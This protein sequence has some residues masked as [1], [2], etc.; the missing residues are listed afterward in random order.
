M[1]WIMD[2]RVGRHGEVIKPEALFG[3]D[4]E[5][6]YE[7]CKKAFHNSLRPYEGCYIPAGL[8]KVME[9]GMQLEKQKGCK[10]TIRDIKEALDKAR[11]SFYNEHPKELKAYVD[12]RQN[13][14]YERDR[15]FRI[16]Y[17]IAKRHHLSVDWYGKDKS[18]CCPDQWEILKN[19]KSIGR[20]CLM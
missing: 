9:I 15:Q 12:S 11:E 3:K 8:P 7:A 10:P 16:I 13:W 6:M 2:T 20:I 17:G 5:R 4:A 14:E 19:G 1:E 18:C